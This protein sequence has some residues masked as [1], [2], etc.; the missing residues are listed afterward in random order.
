MNVRKRMKQQ[1]TMDAWLCSRQMV[2]DQ[3]DEVAD[4]IRDTY[5]FVR[6]AIAPAYNLKAGEHTMDWRAIAMMVI[7]NGFDPEM[8]VMAIAEE[9]GSHMRWN[10]LIGSAAR[11][12]YL[13]RI[14][15]TAKQ[16]QVEDH[17]QLSV[18]YMANERNRGRDFADILLDPAMGFCSLF[19]WCTAVKLELTDIAERFKPPA[20]E[21][22][23]RP[24]YHVVYTKAYPEVFGNGSN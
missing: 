11:E 13:R 22:Y 15:N 8:Y 17:I 20:M 5:V 14:N 3:L 19:I 9:Y 18:L 23:K 24:A 12:V 4:K 7:D 6:R 21:L 2:P 10:S 16:K 1:E